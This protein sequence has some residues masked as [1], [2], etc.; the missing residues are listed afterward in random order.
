MTTMRV[1]PSLG[2]RVRTRHRDQQRL[3]PT[4]ELAPCPGARVFA[5]R[6]LQSPFDETAL[7]AIDRR[8]AHSNRLCNHRV[9][10][11]L[12]RSQQNLR[13]F[14]SAHPGVTA[15]RQLLQLRA[16]LIGEFD[17]VSYV[18]RCLRR[19]C[20]D[21]R[22]W[23]ARDV[24]P[25]RHERLGS[26]SAKGNIWHS[27]M[28]IRRSM[29]ALR[30][31]PTCN[32]ISRSLPRVFTRWCSAWNAK[33]CC[34]ATRGV[35]EV[36]KCSWPRKPSPSCADRTNPIDQNHCAEVLGGGFELSPFGRQQHRHSQARSSG[37]HPVRASSTIWRRKAGGACPCGNGGSRFR[38]SGYLL[39][40]GSGVHE[41]G[42]IPRSQLA[43]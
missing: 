30:L 42:S 1:I 8:G 3:F 38:H 27:S 12:L 2:G 28:P 14:D 35:P 37:V 13:P 40:K 19:C 16:L 39:P 10:M 9:R 25:P 41:I 24:D 4:G 20:G 7:G 29:D 32:A 23:N 21:S 34:A 22:S 31:R 15:A 33:G 18:H 36:S 26:P 11:S 5:Q 43:F 6:P 17:H